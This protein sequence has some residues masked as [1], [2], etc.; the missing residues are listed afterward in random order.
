M[1]RVSCFVIRDPKTLA[2]GTTVTP[3]QLALTCIS[4]H[5][6]VEARDKKAVIRVSYLV[7]REN[8]GRGPGSLQ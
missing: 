6:T 1:I 4:H 5:P 2:G 8:H 3:R 7:I